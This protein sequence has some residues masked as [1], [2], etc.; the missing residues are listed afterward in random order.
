MATYDVANKRFSMRALLTAIGH[1]MNST[2]HTAGTLGDM[3]YA[4]TAGVWTR[5][6]GNTQN[7]R[8][9]LRQTGAGAGVSAAPVWDVLAET[10]LGFSD[11]TTGDVTAAR[12]GFAPKA[13][14]NTT[15][16]L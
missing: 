16:F 6:A 8:F 5:L 1:A 4:G 3:T 15:T 12:H 2:A 7:S 14:G 10:D 9:F 11:V 13:P